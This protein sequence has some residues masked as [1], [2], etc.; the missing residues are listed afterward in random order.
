M[1]GAGIMCPCGQPV[2]QTDDLG[3]GLMPLGGQRGAW[4]GMSCW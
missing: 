1:V 4:L 3:E 2:H